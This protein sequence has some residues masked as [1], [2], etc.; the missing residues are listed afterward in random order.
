MR[1]RFAQAARRHRVGQASARHVLETA[2]P[3]GTLTAQGNPAWWYVGRDERGREL[4]ILAVEV[5]EP[6]P[7]LLVI[8][9]MPTALR[10]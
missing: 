5:L 7:L 3:V 9:V 8:H 10:R 2:T 1:I 4:E 6:E